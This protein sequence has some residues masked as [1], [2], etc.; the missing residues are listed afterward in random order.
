MAV[1]CTRKLRT[2]QSH[3]VHHRIAVQAMRGLASAQDLSCQEKKNQQAH[4]LSCIPDVGLVSDSAELGLPQVQHC[5]TIW[6][7]AQIMR[8][9]WGCCP[10][11]RALLPESFPQ[12]LILHAVQGIVERNT[13]Q[14]MVQV[15]SAHVPHEQSSQSLQI[16]ADAGSNRS[17]LDAHI[18]LTQ[19]LPLI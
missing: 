9:H 3:A 13:S 14:A 2:A 17:H 4:H 11:C 12:E 1:C 5:R 8:S 6:C 16:S 7:P 15:I 19:A 10:C 18:A